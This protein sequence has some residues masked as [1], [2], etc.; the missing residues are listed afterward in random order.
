[1]P[2]R[3]TSTD[4]R[5]AQGCAPVEPATPGKNPSPNGRTYAVE[6]TPS[7]LAGDLVLHPPDSR[8]SH[9]ARSD[10]REKE[11]QVSR[12]PAPP[13]SR[14]RLGGTSPGRRSIHKRGA[15]TCGERALATCGDA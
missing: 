11:L 10:A 13:V 12:H 7:R 3:R 8:G 5:P 6:L 1:L 14:A 15:G 2:S 4:S 9:V